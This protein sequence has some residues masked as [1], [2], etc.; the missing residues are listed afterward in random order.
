MGPYPSYLFLTENFEGAY[1]AL[2]E[3][4]Y[5][6]LESQEPEPTGNVVFGIP[7]A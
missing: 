4:I 3:G 2:A 7:I 6:L 1:R 5:Q